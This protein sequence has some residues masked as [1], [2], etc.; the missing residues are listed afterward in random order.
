MSEPTPEPMTSELAELSDH[1][2]HCDCRQ[3]LASVRSEL[4]NAN[5]RA[6]VVEHLLRK[7]DVA[8]EVQRQKAAEARDETR[9]VGDAAVA[10]IRGMETLHVRQV[11]QL[12]TE[13]ADL[14]LN[15]E[16]WQ[17]TARELRDTLQALMDDRGDC[18]TC[19]ASSDQDCEP[20]CIWAEA[21]RLLE[22]EADG[23]DA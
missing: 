14:R 22:R 23:C 20:A 10:E 1:D 16:G 11:E 8:R 6:R 4:A 2:L 19:G 18:P 7:A 5:Q 21:A 17:R 13:N 15:L 12:Q 9:A 3:D